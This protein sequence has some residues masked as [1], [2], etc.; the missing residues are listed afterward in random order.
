MSKLS[1]K[2]RSSHL[3]CC[4]R[5]SGRFAPRSSP[6]FAMTESR[7]VGVKVLITD[8]VD[9]YTGPPHPLGLL[10]PCNKRQARPINFVNS[11][12]LTDTP[13]LSKRNRTVKLRN[14]NRSHVRF[15]SKADM[16]GNE[17]IAPSRIQ[18]L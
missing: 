9:E 2:M 17:S 1:I 8:R 12:R 3:Q 6:V 18:F 10:G 13:E 5:R 14:W 7:K 4:G 16:C 15:G 11:R